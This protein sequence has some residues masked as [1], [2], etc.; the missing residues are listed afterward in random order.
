M[1][2]PVLFGVLV[3]A[4]M[5]AG[6]VVAI[7]QAGGPTPPTAGTPPKSVTGATVEPQPIE[8][9][10]PAAPP[11][12]PSDPLQPVREA[13]GRAAWADVGFAHRDERLDALADSVR[14]R[15]AEALT[16]WSEMPRAGYRHQAVARAIV[17]AVGAQDR[18]IVLAWLDR[19]PW[20]A[21][22]LE[23]RGWVAPAAPLLRARLAD[24]KRRLPE[25]AEVWAAALAACGDPDDDHVLAETLGR[26]VDAAAQDG[27]ARLL[28]R[29]ASCD[30]RSAVRAAW[31]LRPTSEP[32]ESK[33]PLVPLA[34]EAGEPAA[35]ALVAKVLARGR[36]DK[37][38]AAFRSYV[39]AQPAFAGS[40]P[41]A[42][43]LAEHGARLVFR[44]EAWQLAAEAP[45]TAVRQP[46]AP[47]VRAGSPRPPVVADAPI[48]APPEGLPADADAAAVRAL[49]DALAP[50]VAGRSPLR[51]DDPVVGQLAAIPPAHLGELI[52]ASM[53]H[54]TNGAMQIYCEFAVLQAVRQQHRDQVLAA[55]PRSPYLVK[56]VIDRGWQDP[57]APIM[58]KMLRDPRLANRFADRV[59]LVHA[60]CQVGD[61]ADHAA[62]REALLD[63]RLGYHQAAMATALR[64]LPGFDLDGAVQAAWGRR[65]RADYGDRQEAFCVIAANCGVAEAL[66]IAV[67]HATGGEVAWRSSSLAEEARRTLG[68]LLDTEAEADAIA[69]WW[70]LSRGQVRWDGARRR[71]LMSEPPAGRAPPTAAGANDF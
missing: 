31:S 27:L 21:A 15:L 54:Q 61:P 24:H 28:R 70:E 63:M 57:A 19:A 42:D 6:F 37:R 53:R 4:G 8:R 7:V 58:R 52:A 39:L 33:L 32:A 20:L 36:G 35:V 3:A 48:P 55:L 23:P 22:T 66:P 11:P 67:A 46:A 71:W 41:D 49:I 13:V 9:P 43:W 25:G 14:G 50:T 26:L 16:V 47:A 30:W 5:L 65:P 29:R 17:L 38:I 2:R 64:D 51:R 60:L 10:S 34:M 56:A 12:P 68:R 62:L 69:R 18:D 44:D 45:A 59:D 1:P 40:I